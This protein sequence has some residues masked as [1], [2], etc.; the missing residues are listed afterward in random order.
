MFLFVVSHIFVTLVGLNT[1]KIELLMFLRKLFVANI[2]ILF[3][4]SPNNFVYIFLEDRD[5]VNGLFESASETILSWFHD[6]NKSR[7]FT[8]GIMCTL[9]TFG[10]DLKWNQHIHM[11][12]SESGAGNI[13]IFRKVPHISF[14]ALRSRWQKILLSY[15]SENLLSSKLNTFKKFWRNGQFQ[16]FKMPEDQCLSN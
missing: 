15:L 5:L 14:K 13:E 4:L 7:N 3:L 2:D 6:M 10:R 1:H 11:F 8:P 12:C 9:H 16:I